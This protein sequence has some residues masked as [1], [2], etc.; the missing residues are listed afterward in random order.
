MDEDGETVVDEGKQPELTFDIKML[1]Q[2]P[3]IEDPNPPE[4]IVEPVK[5]KAPPPKKGAP[6]PTN[7]P[8]TPPPP[9]MITPEPE[10]ME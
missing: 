3:D 5:G 10:V 4:E 1:F 6:P 9:K 2:G 8:L 7:D